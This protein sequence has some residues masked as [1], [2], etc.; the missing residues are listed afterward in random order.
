MRRNSTCFAAS[1]TRWKRQSREQT[2]TPISKVLL[3]R[4]SLLKMS[5]R[6]LARAPRLLTRI[7]RP[8]PG[9]ESGKKEPGELD[10]PITFKQVWLFL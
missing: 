4:V 5:A 7:P 6:K 2:P 8:R 1:R 3:L 10:G 9:A